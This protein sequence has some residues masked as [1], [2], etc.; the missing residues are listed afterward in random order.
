MLENESIFA[1]LQADLH[2]GFLSKLVTFNWARQAEQAV[3]GALAISGDATTAHASRLVAH[4]EPVYRDLRFLESI[5]LEVSS[6]LAAE[7][8]AVEREKEEISS[9]MLSIF[10]RHRGA[11]RV[12]EGRAA[13]LRRVG[14]LWTEARDSLSLGIHAFNGVRSDLTALSE[15]QPGLKIARLHLPADEQGRSFKGWVR[16]LEARRVL[17][18]AQVGV[19]SSPSLHLTPSDL[20]FVS[21]V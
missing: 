14:Q 4:G 13:E 9:K 20:A 19:P 10:G 7:G 8:A 6:L 5:A 17:T 1:K 2:P 11:L 21:D 15:N 3:L 16:R 12:L 18:P